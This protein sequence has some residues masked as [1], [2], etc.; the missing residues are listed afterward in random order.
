MRRPLRSRS[1]H[2]LTEAFEP[3]SGRRVVQVHASLSGRRP[4]TPEILPPDAN[5][6]VQRLRKLEKLLDRQFTVA[7]VRFGIDSVIGLVPAVGDLITGALG[8]DL[9]G[10]AKR[11]CISKSMLARMS[12]NWG[13]DVGIAALP[14]VGDIL[15]LAFKSDARKLRLLIAH[16]G[17]REAQV[18]RPGFS[19]PAL[20]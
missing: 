12:A 15:H 4:A 19:Q 6:D 10:Q 1:C 18:A 3:F 11:C 14:I 7:G 5:P 9:I 8:L 16:L 17:K 2:R 13:I 20:D